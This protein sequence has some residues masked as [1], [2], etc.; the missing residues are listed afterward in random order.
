MYFLVSSVLFLVSSQKSWWMN[1]IHFQSC[2]TS[3]YVSLIFLGSYSPWKWSFLSKSTPD[4]NM[5]QSM[6]YS[7]TDPSSEGKLKDVVSKEEWESKLCLAKRIICVRVRVRVRVKVHK[8]LLHRWTW[9][10]SFKFTSNFSLLIRG[11][12]LQHQEWK[13]KSNLPWFFFYPFAHRPTWSKVKFQYQTIIKDLFG[14]KYQSCQGS[15]LYF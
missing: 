2:V 15:I 10:Y 13:L 14:V 12:C 3:L 9:P 8:L 5:T 11:R 4:N 1:S 6:A 7:F